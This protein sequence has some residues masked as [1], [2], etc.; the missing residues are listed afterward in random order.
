MLRI[1]HFSK[2]YAPGRYAVQDLTLHVAPR[3]DLRVPGPQRRGKSTTLR[4]VAGVLDFTEGDIIVAAAPSAPGRCR[5]SRPWRFCRI[6]PT[7]TTSSPAS[8]TSTLSR[9][10]AASGGPAHRAHRAL[11][12]GLCPHCDLGSPIGSYSHGMKQKLALISAFLRQ[13]KLLLLDEPF[14]GLDPNAAYTLKQLLR[15]LCQAGGRCSSPPTCW[16][17][18][19]SSATSWP[20]CGPVA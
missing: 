3:R 6:T 12:R 14:V 9:M 20:S 2:Q 5:P 16:R 7:C 8:S 10:S 19:K 1:E 18:P 17:W 4:A 15:Q 13:P 11:C